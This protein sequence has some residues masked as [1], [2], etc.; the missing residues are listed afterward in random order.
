[1]ISI[2]TLMDASSMLAEGVI[3]TERTVAAF[4]A[5]AGLGRAV[6]GDWVGAA[7]GRAAAGAAARVAGAA[8]VAGDGVGAA[9]GRGSAAQPRVVLRAWPLAARRAS[10]LVALGIE[11]TLRSNWLW[12]LQPLLRRLILLQRRRLRRMG[13][14]RC[15]SRKD[16]GVVRS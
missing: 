3:A 6:T 8:G 13:L 15:R 16:F 12:R 5:A 10:V 14:R 11:A 9:A 1:M 2:G 4:G 7:V